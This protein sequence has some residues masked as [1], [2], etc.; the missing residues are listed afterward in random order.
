MANLLKI[1]LLLPVQRDE[2]EEHH[3]ECPERRAAV[4]DERQR[5]AYDRHEAYGHAYIDK[6][7]HEEAACQT[8]AVDARERF[9]AAF[10]VLGDSENQGD[11]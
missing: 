9:A 4:A 6:Q 1:L 7:M 10:G 5:D 3:C 2:D 8:V 11:V